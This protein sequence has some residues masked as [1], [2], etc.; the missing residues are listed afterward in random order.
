M[1]VHVNINDI[2]LIAQKAG[3]LIMGVYNDKK[4]AQKVDFKTDS[5]PLTEADRKSHDHIVCQLEKLYPHIPVI[6]EEGKNIP[7][8]KR[9]DWPLFWLVDPLDGTK[10]FLNRNGQFTVNIALIDGNAPAFGLVYPP[11][12]GVYYFTENGKAYAMDAKGAKKEL[13]V[14]NKK[15]N[16]VAVRS[17][18]HAA[19]EEEELFKRYHVTD[20]VSRGSA[21]KFCMIA[22]G[23]ADLYYRF[24]P[25]MEWDTAAGQAIVEAA[26]GK[27]YDGLSQKRF[28]YNKQSLVNG[29]FLCTGF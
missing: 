6:S 12:L 9:R 14:A 17:R 25:T 4:Y 26:G 24:K 22:D 13:K 2:L 16:L 7:Y 20:Y 27:V 15:E 28:S 18:S 11:F 8:E 3:E 19:P 29:S 21:L 1:A 23:S 10:E 5:S